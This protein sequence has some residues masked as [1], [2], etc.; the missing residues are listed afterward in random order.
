MGDALFD[1]R[2]RLLDPIDRIS[3]VLFGLIMAITIVGSLS[4]AESGRPTVRATIAAALGCNLAWGLVDA[5]MYLVRALT[6]RT[7][8]LALA[9]RM[10]DSEPAD[11]RRLIAQSLPPEIASLTGAEELEGMRRRLLDCPLAS[12]ATLCRDD[13]TAAVGVFLLVVVATFPVILP[14]MLVRDAGL[15]MNI[16]RATALAMLFL[17]GVALGRYAGYARPTSTGL[18]MAAVG[19]VL[20]AAVKVLG[21]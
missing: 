12:R 17:G 11:A 9:R 21:G 6:Q 3:E 4:V 10:I 5:V 16:S 8:S 19:A 7:R 13:Y 14:L 20:I 15:A 1:R 18:V 2:G